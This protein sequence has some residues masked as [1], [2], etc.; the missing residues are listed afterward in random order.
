MVRSYYVN[1]IS[2]SNV[3]EIVV[4]LVRLDDDSAV[5]RETLYLCLKNQVSFVLVNLFKL[6]NGQSGYRLA[7]YCCHSLVKIA[8]MQD[9]E[10]GGLAEL[11]Q[12]DI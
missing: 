2:A 9:I 7:R 5:L 4:G 6:E 8:L 1:S 11:N 3:E 10:V 12:L